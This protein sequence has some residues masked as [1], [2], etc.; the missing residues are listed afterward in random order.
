MVRTSAITV[1]KASIVT[2]TRR[3]TPRTSPRLRVWVSAW[4][5]S[6]DFS[7]SR[8]PTNRPRSVAAVMIPKPP[9]WM[10]P[11]ITTWPNG[12]Q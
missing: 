9:I 2:A 3:M 7:L 4:A 11:R 5:I 10:S 8:P 6:E 12:D 1:S